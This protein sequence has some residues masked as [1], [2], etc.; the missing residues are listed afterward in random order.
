MVSAPTQAAG[1]AG[2]GART[3]RLLEPEDVVLA[4]W[5]GAIEPVI[6]WY[7]GD[8]LLPLIESL[9][10]RLME[11]TW[12]TRW[13][14]VAQ[15]GVVM[16]A[17]LSIAL[18]PL[19]VALLAPA[20]A[21]TARRSLVVPAG[22]LGT[23]L[24]RDVGRAIGSAGDHGLTMTGAVHVAGALLPFVLLVAAP[25]LAAGATREWRV[26][27]VRFTLFYAAWWAGAIAPW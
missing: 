1:R 21:S 7:T 11:M 13:A 27:L 15:P 14:W 16:G 9:D 12:D 8:Q 4:V 23:S 20:L 26:W 18:I 5:L 3:P 6:R 17:L 19:A 24:C 22:L 25:R 2:S 10:L